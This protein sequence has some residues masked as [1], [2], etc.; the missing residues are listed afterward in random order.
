MKLNNSMNYWNISSFN[1]EYNYVPN[2]KWLFLIIC[3]KENI[4][5][6]KGRLHTTTKINLI[7]IVICTHAN[8][9]VLS[10]FKNY[11]TIKNYSFVS[12]LRTTTI[13]LWLPVTTINPFHIIRADETI[14]PKLSI[15]YK[16]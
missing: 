7:K 11:K 4:S 15:W 5:P 1:F 3:E 10:D 6:V 14:I 8:A 9:L 16:Y 2:P 13:G 12:H